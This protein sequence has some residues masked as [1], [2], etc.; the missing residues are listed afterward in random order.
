MTETVYSCTENFDTLSFRY[1]I[2]TETPFC[3]NGFVRIKTWTSNV[4]N[5]G[6]KGLNNG[7]VKYLESRIITDLSK[8]WVHT[9]FLYCFPIDSKHWNKQYKEHV[10]IQNQNRYVF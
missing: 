9:S 3:R 8:R 6:V 5:S 4:R 1:L 10:H 2:M 7:N